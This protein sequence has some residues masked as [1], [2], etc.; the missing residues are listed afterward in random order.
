MCRKVAEAIRDGKD[1]IEIW[2]ARHRLAEIVCGIAPV[3]ASI[4]HWGGPSG[5]AIAAA[6][7]G[8]CEDV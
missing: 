7:V 5:E 8:N 1:E 2:P 3:G 4:P 6:E